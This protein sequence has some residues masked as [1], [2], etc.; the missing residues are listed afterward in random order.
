MGAGKK[1]VEAFRRLCYNGDESYWK[2]DRMTGREVIGMFRKAFVLIMIVAS[3]AGAAFAELPSRGNISLYADQA[4]LY[5]AYCP[6]G[7]GHGIGR[8]EMWVWCLPGETGLSGV[9]F[10]VGYPPNAVRDRIVYNSV[11]SAVAGD[12]DGCSAFFGACQWDWCWVAYQS[13]YVNS[14][15][16][17]LVE[18]V[19]HP[20]AGVFQF[21]NC[22]PGYPNEP[23]L[24]G[25]SLYINDDSLPCLPPETAIGSEGSTWGA[26]KDL[27]GE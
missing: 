26:V 8:I 16:Q 7:P 22:E 18:I 6:L 25:T 3:C 21:S 5:N 1:G 10:A 12:L 9:Q 14:P 15:E 27:Y 4:R 23:C 24:K 13:L 20:V 11:L 2:T 19:A 17:T